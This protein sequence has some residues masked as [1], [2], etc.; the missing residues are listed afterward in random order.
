MALE[1]ISYGFRVSIIIFVLTQGRREDRWWWDQMVS[2]F[3][4]EYTMVNW[5]GGPCNVHTD[6]YL[7]LVMS[8]H[9]M[10]QQPY[11]E[12]PGCWRNTMGLPRI[13]PAS[14]IPTLNFFSLQW[15]SGV[16]S[17]GDNSAVRDSRFPVSKYTSLYITDH[18]PH[19]SNQAIRQPLSLRLS[20]LHAL[21][22][23][24][25]GSSGVCA[26]PK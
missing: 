8:Q 19:L 1:K 14:L 7:L 25:R 20:I 10:I 23:L 16:M 21:P 18:P 6:R 9:S 12:Y 26:L 5:K 4:E 22:L 3:I 17:A 24:R 11:D 15:S 2:Y 13:F